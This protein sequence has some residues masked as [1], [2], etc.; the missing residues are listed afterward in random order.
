MVFILHSTGLWLYTHTHT[1]IYVSSRSESSQDYTAF[2]PSGSSVPFNAEQSE[3]SLP[4][5][6]HTD[7]L[8]DPQAVRL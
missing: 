4:G 3:L 1:Y 8:E 5:F 6:H 7:I 2:I